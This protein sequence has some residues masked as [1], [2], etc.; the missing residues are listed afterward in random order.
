ME[1]HTHSNTLEWNI[2][3]DKLYDT[4]NR[5]AFEHEWGIGRSSSLAPS[6]P[7][8][9]PFAPAKGSSPPSL[10]SFLGRFA[11]YDGRKQSHRACGPLHWASPVAAR[12]TGMTL[13][14]RGLSEA[15]APVCLA[16][17]PW[18]PSVEL[19]LRPLHRGGR[20]VRLQEHSQREQ[21]LH[22]S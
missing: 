20:W 18:V 19:T 12:G 6:A 17:E 2:S 16:V 10:P 8:I 21:H 7:F 9:P 3:L 22:S 13:E 15:V 4:E 5:N 11:H 14:D 1:V